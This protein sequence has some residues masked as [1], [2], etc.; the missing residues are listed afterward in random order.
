MFA[1]PGRQSVFANY[2]KQIGQN[3][4][5]HSVFLYLPCLCS[6][7]MQYHVPTGCCGFRISLCLIQIR[8]LSCLTCKQQN[9][10]N[11]PIEGS[12][13]IWIPV[14]YV[15]V[16]HRNEICQPESEFLKARKKWARYGGNGCGFGRSW[17][18]FGINRP[19]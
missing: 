19:D 6:S 4:D 9:N 16:L 14:H 1:Q 12:F 17:A 11:G 15:I 18:F 10:N 3:C 8:P 5:Y 13:L 2:V 7:C